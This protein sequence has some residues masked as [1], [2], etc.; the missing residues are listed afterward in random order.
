MPD[1]LLR[2][3]EYQTLRGVELSHEQ[4]L[5]L[6]SV[7]PSVTIGASALGDGLYD[8]T[9]GSVVG[10]ARVD[11]LSV[12]ISP[13]FGIPSLA[14]MLGYSYG[15][16]AWSEEEF[17]FEDDA[18]LTEL[19][20]PGFISALAK[21][22]G[23]GVLQGYKVVED[24]S[25]TVRGRIRF[26][27]QLRY[28]YGFAPPAEIRYDEFTEDIAE[29]QLLKAALRQLLA[30]RISHE[31][32]RRALRV[33][34]SALRNVALVEY[35]RRRLPEVPINRLNG[36][37]AHALQIAKL[38]LRSTA[39]EVEA[40]S[41]TSSAFTVDMNEVF[42]DFVVSALRSELGLSSRVFPQN[43]CGRHLRFDVGE[44]IKLKPDFSWW[45]GGLCRL[46]G[47]VKYKRTDD[48]IKHPDL[49]QLNAY[50]TAT[51]LPE[52]IL[53]YA[54]GEALPTTHR[55]KHTGT[56]LVVRILD[57]RGEPRKVL[58]RV[59]ELAAEVVEM[60]QR[61]SLVPDQILA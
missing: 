55:V 54:A 12:L 13:K 51:G 56:E 57:V 41:L 5:A 25:S 29:N 28:R 47:D 6:A 3:T 21:A 1:R 8:L 30:L 22:L 48:A 17:S 34:S 52:G 46:V 26:D 16:I 14:F 4:R 33:Y 38:I 11:G 35:D 43:A 7:L 37:Y 2:L 61:A 42:E 58:E 20:V 15:R 32:H 24:S 49:Y 23:P 40:G 19:I 18:S 50:A 44:T 59:R 9:P 36:R 39:I 60:K 53:I 45:E 27:D 10:A 31:P